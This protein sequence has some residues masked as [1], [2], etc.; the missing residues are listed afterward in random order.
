MP[1]W[2]EPLTLQGHHVSIE[3]MTAVH[4]DEIEAAAADGALWNLWYTSVPD[5]QGLEGWMAVAL[6]Q[7]EEAGAM[8]FVIRRKSDSKVVGATRYFNVAA[9]NRRLEIGHTF[10]SRS[11]HRTAVNSETK[12][13]LLR[14]A[15]ETL[16][17]AGVELRT[18]FMNHQSRSAIERLGAKLDGI[19]RC[20]QIMPDG[21]LR[22]TCVYSIVAHEWPAV[23]NHLTFRLSRD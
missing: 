12:L 14:H 18:H 23:R 11:V 16:N 20:H 21:S 13:L 3:P 5:P 22:D 4:R 2:I 6:K 17:C 15:F 10:Y 8:P 7:R 19:L 1:R 9:E